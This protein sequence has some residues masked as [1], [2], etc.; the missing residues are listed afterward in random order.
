MKNKVIKIVVHTIKMLNYTEDFYNYSNIKMLYR[1][2]VF[3]TLIKLLS[4]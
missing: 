1:G 3:K 2:N 4:E